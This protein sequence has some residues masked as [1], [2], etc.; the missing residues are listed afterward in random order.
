MKGI[1]VPVDGEPTIEDIAGENGSAYRGLH[2]R[3]PE[4][5]DG[6]RLA[7]DVVGYVGDES[8]IDGSPSNVHARSVADACYQKAAGRNYHTDVR[9]LMVILG[10]TV[11]GESIDVPADFLA[12]H[13]PQVS[14]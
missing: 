6:I 4:C 13:F 1:V 7:P 8:L 12:E 10:V 14:A 11:N 2:L 9:G 3:F 5:F